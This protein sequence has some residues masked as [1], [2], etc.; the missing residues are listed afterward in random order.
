[1]QLIINH[2]GFDCKSSLPLIDTRKGNS[3]TN[4]ASL[5]NLTAAV[6]EQIQVKKRS[7]EQIILQIS[8]PS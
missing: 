2:S 7:G 5:E 4:H 3:A 6:S 8:A 1:M